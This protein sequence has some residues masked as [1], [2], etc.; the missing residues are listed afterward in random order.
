MTTIN[1]TPRHFR[2]LRALLAG[3]VSRED[4]DRIAGASNGPDEVM[5]LR[6]RFGLQIPCERRKGTDR[7]RRCVEFGVYSL[8]RADAPRVAALLG[9]RAAP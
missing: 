9:G 7:D 6:R 8:A 5:K 1:L 2:V 3:P 4:V